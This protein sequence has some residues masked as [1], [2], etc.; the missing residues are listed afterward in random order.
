MP[1][2][3]KIMTQRSINLEIG[4]AVSSDPGIAIA[5][6]TQRYHHLPRL[7]REMSDSGV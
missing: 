3:A 5:H 6:G 7:S 4:S 2:P 1:Y